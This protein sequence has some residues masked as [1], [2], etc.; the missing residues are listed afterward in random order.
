M[1]L[2]RVQAGTAVYH[3]DARP[4]LGS[5]AVARPSAAEL[6]ASRKACGPF[7]SAG[8]KRQGKNQWAQPPKQ[9][10]NVHKHWQVKM[11]T[12]YGL[13]TAAILTD[14]P[15][16]ANSFIFLAC[17]GFYNGLTFHRILP[18]FVIQGGDPKGDGTGGPGYAF[19]DEKVKH[20][21]RIG[22]LAMA[23]AGPNTNGSQFFIIQ[24][25]EG[26]SLPPQYNLFGQVTTGIAVVN[27]IAN[28]P[29]HNAPGS[30]DPVPSTPNHPV[31][32]TTL[33]VQES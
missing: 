4:A 7:L 11:Y 23:N 19:P 33:T 10:I 8:Q 14:S 5:S 27:K 18:N 3:L 15:I 22:S 26:V 9:V 30:Q 17:Q 32:I 21:Y 12:S 13:I 31:V 2:G 24:G 1:S 28:A 25:S 29:A 20:P 16:T 6:A